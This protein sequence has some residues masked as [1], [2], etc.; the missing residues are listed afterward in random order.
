MLSFQQWVDSEGGQRACSRKFGLS[1]ASVGAWYRLERF[2]RSSS[3]SR[4][5]QCSGY[6]VDFTMLLWRFICAN[7]GPETQPPRRFMKSNLLVTDIAGLKKVLAEFSIPVSRVDSVG[8]HLIAGWSV[9]NVVVG[10]IRCAVQGLAETGQDA[11]D[12][13]RIHAAILENRTVALRR[14]TQ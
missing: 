1:P 14:L 10:E 11:G 8:L 13:Q 4:I 7:T 5:L 6:Q 9:I 12:I 2:P 3:Q